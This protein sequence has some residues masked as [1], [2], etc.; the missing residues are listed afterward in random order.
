M[1]LRCDRCGEAVSPELPA[2][3]EFEG[4]ALCQGCVPESPAGAA[5]RPGEPGAT[6]WPPVAVVDID[7]RLLD[8]LD[9]GGQ[10]AEEAR[11]AVD[12]FRAELLAEFERQ[13]PTFRDAYLSLPLPGRQALRQYLTA[14]VALHTQEESSVCDNP[15]CLFR[16]ALDCC[17]LQPAESGSPYAGH[18]VAAQYEEVLFPKALLAA[19]GAWDRGCDFRIRGLEELEQYE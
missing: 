15:F 13:L 5:D 2:L 3:A 11:A 6:L 7:G 19:L 1:I 12:T 18:Y 8:A 16:V 17:R 4:V 10:E 14:V 9:V